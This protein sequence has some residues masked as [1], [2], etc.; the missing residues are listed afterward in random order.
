MGKRTKH[1]LSAI[2]LLALIGGT[3]WI[4]IDANTAP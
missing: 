4:L 2:F 3:V 1:I